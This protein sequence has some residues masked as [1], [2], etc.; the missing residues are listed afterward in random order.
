MNTM[1]LKSKQL[2]NIQQLNNGDYFVFENSKHLCKLFTRSWHGTRLRRSDQR[3][4]RSVEVTKH[5][6]PAKLT[7]AGEFVFNKK[8]S[9]TLKPFISPSPGNREIS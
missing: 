5:D 8:H 1:I 4:E 6:S 2:L 7:F 3:R 9:T